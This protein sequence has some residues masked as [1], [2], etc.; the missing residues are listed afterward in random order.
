MSESIYERF[1][2]TALIL[3]DINIHGYLFLQFLANLSQLFSMKL[4]LFSFL[5]KNKSTQNMPDIKSA[6]ICP[7][8][9]VNIVKL[10]ANINYVIMKRTETLPP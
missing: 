10:F 1:P 9:L 8:K 4:A 2:L 6:K 3:K 7:L 5:F